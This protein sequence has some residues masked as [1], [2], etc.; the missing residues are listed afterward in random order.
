MF[1]NFL[2]YLNLYRRKI[3]YIKTSYS[4]NA[5]DLIIN[6]IFKKKH[7]GFYLDVGCQHP[8]SN[9]N[10]FLLFKRG[11]SGINIDLDQ[12][13]IKLFNI[14]RP[15]DL[16][17]NLALSSSI[18]EKN[19]YFYHDKSPINTLD[20]TVSDFQDATIKEIRKIKTTS[21]NITLQNIK[22]NK[23]IDYMNLDV[24]GH[25][26]DVLKGFNLKHYKPSVISIEFLDLDMK[27]LELKNN[28]L[29]KI[30]KSELYN[31]MIDNN[32]H[33]VNWLHGDLIF[34]HEDFRD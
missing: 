20:K 21:L 12:E 34:V 16:N 2:K 15:N 8:I 7:N 28:N 26:L 14:A 31:Y 19:L 29:K 18:K 10:T 33:F 5:V 6:Y 4:L 22:F 27:F 32:Y 23:K 13:N 17:L 3:K 24:E 25:E 11:W 1:G 9:N 30:I